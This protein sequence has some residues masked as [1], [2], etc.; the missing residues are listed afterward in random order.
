MP[1]MLMVSQGVGY[2]CSCPPEPTPAEALTIADAVFQGTIVDQRAVL[3][4]G[5]PV[6]RGP[7]IEYDV[8][9]KRAWKGVSERRVSLL[10]TNVCSPSF[11]VGSTAL[12]YAARHDGELIVM[13][14]MPTRYT[15]KVE[16]DVA[17]FGAPPV[18]TFD[19]PATPV[20]ASLPFSRRIRAHAVAGIWVFQ[21]LY[22]WWPD[23]EPSWD[24]R[25]LCGAF[26]VQILAA[27]VLLA[28]RRWW[29]GASVL[30]SS[31]ATAVITI[32]WVGHRLLNI[33]GG[34]YD[35]FLTW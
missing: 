1:F 31:A 25:L 2:A 28:S 32:F 12:I 30:A 11:H 7:G 9:V 27:V 33:D 17:Q 14:C 23:I 18:F 29:R 10:R 22:A 4:K 34:W 19:G 20:A 3:L 5:D 13:G 15:S 35:P 21:S 6:C 16:T 24:L 26:A 8:I